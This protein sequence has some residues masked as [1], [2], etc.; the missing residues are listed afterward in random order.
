MN[1]AYDGTIKKKQFSVIT[2]VT[3]N[4]R[5]TICKNVILVHVIHGGIL[6]YVSVTFINKIYPS[7][8]L[9]RGDYWR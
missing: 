1:F 5:Q 6:N 4:A 2:I 9:K 7:Y 3:H 8:S